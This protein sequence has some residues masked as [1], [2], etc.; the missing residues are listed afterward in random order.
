MITHNSALADMAHAVFRL[1]G[2]EVVE[3]IKNTELIPAERIEW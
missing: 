3:A 1:R 2:G